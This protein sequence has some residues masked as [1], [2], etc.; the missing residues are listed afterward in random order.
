[1]Q[2]Y[3]A[4][5]SG[6][7]SYKLKPRIAQTAM[8]L[9]KIYLA[10]SVA[11]AVCLYAAGMSLFDAVCH[12]F[13]TLGTGGFST[14]TASIA[15]FS[16]L[17]QYILVVFMLLASLSFVQHYRLWTE[18]RP[19]T[20]LCDFELIT[21]FVVVG[22]A[23]GLVWLYLVVHDGYGLERG[24]RGALFQVTSIAS[25][26]GFATEDF[27]RWHGFAQ[28]ILLT[29]MFIG[30]CTGSTAGGIKV[31]RLDLLGR[32]VA[33]EFKRMVEANAVFAVRL[34][35]RV[36][37]EPAVQ[38]VLNL[39]YLALLLNFVSVLL[40]AA[41]GSD[42]LTSI[43]AVTASMFNVGPGLGDVGPMDNYGHLPVLS[44]WVLSFCM[45]AGRLE[46]Y[47]LIVIVTP[48]FWRR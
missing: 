32:V 38:S 39:V 16:P 45:I 41:A 27:E 34:G 15:A 30:G 3:R 26:T 17:V 1:M 28:I 13:S 8:A 25:T 43:S 18:R 22:A 29:L 24:L 37:G 2:L 12:T 40:L 7:R 42:V 33:R 10:L 35:G 44:K 6:A 5:F 23:S 14:R 21:F 46:F 48:A 20:F 47:T 36:F 31:A 11:L 19:R 9:W 4:E